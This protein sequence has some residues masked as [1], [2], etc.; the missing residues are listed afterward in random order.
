MGIPAENPDIDWYLSISTARGV[1]PRCPFAS[2]ERCPRYYQSL[3]LL[4]EA[5]STKIPSAEDDRLKAFWEKS[6]LWPRTDEQATSISGSDRSKSF[7]EFCPEVMHDRF[8]VFV[9]GLGTYGD[10]LDREPAFRQLTQ[11]GIPATHWRWIWEWLK[12]LHFTECPL[13]SPLN[14]GGST[15]QR[16]QEDLITIKPTFMGMSADLRGLWRQAFAWWKS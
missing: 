7:S 8:G 6:D 4:G 15:P 2:V 10:D 13:Y 14:H 16:K 12:P 3:S 1:T 5:G 9:K 11:Q